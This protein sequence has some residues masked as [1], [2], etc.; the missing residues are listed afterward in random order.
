MHAN[1]L[2]GVFCGSVCFQ[3]EALDLCDRGTTWPQPGTASLEVLCGGGRDGACPGGT[4][5]AGAGAQPWRCR[6][7]AARGGTQQPHRCA[8]SYRPCVAWG[9]A[10]GEHVS[11]R[12]LKERG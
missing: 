4:W 5:R 3:W 1:A 6:V 7:W 11:K 8:A 12:H 10:L 2:E 9:S